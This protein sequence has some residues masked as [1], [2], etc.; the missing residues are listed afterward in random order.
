[1]A[2]RQTERSSGAGGSLASATT[3]RGG[4]GDGNAGNVM[5]SLGLANKGREKHGCA[6]DGDGEVGSREAGWD[7]G[8]FQRIQVP[9]DDQPPARG[10]FSRRHRHFYETTPAAT[11]SL[12]RY[13]TK[14]LT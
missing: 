6:V 3:R 10:A 14:P 2:S 4:S 7:R 13:R 12:I 11:G 1:M 8:E 9:G 5:R